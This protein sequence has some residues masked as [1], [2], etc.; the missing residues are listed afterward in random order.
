MAAQQAI[1]FKLDFDFLAGFEVSE[2]GTLQTGVCSENIHADAIAD[3]DADHRIRDR[4]LKDSSDAHNDGFSGAESVTGLA[5]G[6]EYADLL[7]AAG[8]VPM[9]KTSLVRYRAVCDSLLQQPGAAFL[10]GALT[11]EH[12]ADVAI[13]S[14]FRRALHYNFSI[15]H[16][17]GAI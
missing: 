4:L 5:V 14:V 16:K 15:Q 10:R 6:A 7:H 2:L 9:A 3:Q 12:K 13:D 1:Q 8:A 11:I 17:G